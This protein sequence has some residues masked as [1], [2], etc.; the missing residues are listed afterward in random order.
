VRGVVDFWSLHEPRRHARIRPR[1]LSH[2]HEGACPFLHGVYNHSLLV[3]M[4]T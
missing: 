3:V 1:F 2:D 4:D